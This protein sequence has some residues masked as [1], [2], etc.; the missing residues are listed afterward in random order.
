MSF[1]G[2]WIDKLI[3]VSFIEELPFLPSLFL[4][5]HKLS[6]PIP[7]SQTFCNW[8]PGFRRSD[9]YCWAENR[10]VVKGT[11]WNRVVSLI[12]ENYLSPTQNH[13][14]K[15]Y[16]LFWDLSALIAMTS[17]RQNMTINCRIF[18]RVR[19]VLDIFGLYL[20]IQI[21]DTKMTS[22]K[23][24]TQVSCKKRYQMIRGVGR[25]LLI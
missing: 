23:A 14:Y 1:L 8:W 4:S 22:P 3:K 18:D 5:N 7:L 13:K 21:N 25:D 15:I 10:K 11:Y 9:V 16:M 19:W 12:L 6:R 24:N 17:H 20:W 2:K